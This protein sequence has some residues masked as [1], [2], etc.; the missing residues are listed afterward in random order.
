VGYGPSPTAA[1][2]TNATRGKFTSGSLIAFDATDA[3]EIYERFLGLLAGDPV[4]VS[5]ETS[6]VGDRKLLQVVAVKE[7][8]DGRCARRLVVSMGEA[9]AMRVL[10]VQG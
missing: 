5:I 9:N 7:V 6:V 10:L 4:V 8:R 3:S 1:V 2:T